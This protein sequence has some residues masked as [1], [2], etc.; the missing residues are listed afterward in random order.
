MVSKKKTSKAVT[1]TAGSAWYTWIL[2]LVVLF[3]YGKTMKF[4]FV[5]DDDLFIRNNPVVQ[6]GVS[7]I[8]DAFNRP[9]LEHFKG[10]N[11]QMYRPAVITAFCIE[12][13]IFRFEPGPYHFVNLLLY[14]LICLLVYRLC[15]N[16]FPKVH[17]GFAFLAALVYAVHPVHSEV[18]AN[19]KGQDE[20]WATFGALMSFKLF[21]DYIER[22]AV[23]KTLFASVGFFLLS[24][25]SKESSVAF[26]ALFPVTAFL[27]KGRSV[28]DSL[29]RSLPW[30]A[31]VL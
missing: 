22:P 5:L 26:F 7:G 23:G 25:F 20:L 2:L 3:M 29:L 31:A 8:P 10:S 28:K 9:S 30:L 24:L 6:R 21:L 1:S 18:V 4:G 27:L 11:F 19:V 13:S 16:L 17:P 14:S 12:Q 15:R